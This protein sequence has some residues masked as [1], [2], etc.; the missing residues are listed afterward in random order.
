MQIVRSGAFLATNKADDCTYCNYRGICGDVDSVVAASAG[1]ARR[2]REPATDSDAGAAQW[3]R[4]RTKPTAKP[5]TEGVPPD[6]EHRQRILRELDTT[7][8]VEAAAGTGKTTSMVGRM[9]ALAPRRQM[10]RRHFG[11]RHVYAQEHGR[12]AG[13]LS[14][15]AGASGRQRVWP[16]RASAWPSRCSTSSAASSARSTRSAPGSCANGRSRR[17]VDLAFSELDG[18]RGC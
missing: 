16:R 2:S 10:P 17:R 11:C 4:N 7:M 14:G 15:C 3:L 5:S 8:L 6:H 1:Q 12:T 9:V 13:P 18:F